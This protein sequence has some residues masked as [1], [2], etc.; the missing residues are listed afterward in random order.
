ME[1]ENVNIKNWK[2]LIKP[3]KLDV[4]IS[5]ITPSYNRA[6]ELPYLIES[7]ERQSINLNN[8][9]LI[10]SDDGSTD[11]TSKIISDWSKKTSFEIKY[12]KQKNKGPGAARNHG[13]KYSTGE[14][15]L[16]V[17]SDC[18]THREWLKNIIKIYDEESFDA[19]GGPDGSK[20]DFTLLQKAI[21]F[22][23]TSTI[24]TGGIR[25]HGDKRFTKSIK[26]TR[27]I[28]DQIN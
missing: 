13:L 10:I 27:S 22:S 28:F 9:E 7:I 14:L 20:S 25:G 5:I 17:D 6:E 18:E 26:L 16:F 19:F 15:I 21:D 24:T 3:A 4:K 11:K 8:L 2:S 12:I 1:I 23:M